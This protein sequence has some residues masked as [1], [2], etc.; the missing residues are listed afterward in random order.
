MTGGLVYGDDHPYIGLSGKIGSNFTW[1]FMYIIV[2]DDIDFGSAGGSIMDG[3][4]LDWRV[5]SIKGKYK[6]GNGFIISP[7]YAFSDNSETQSQDAKVHYFGAEAYGKLGLLTPRFEFAY[8]TGETNI[9]PAT[10]LEYD[11]D[12]FAWYGSVDVNI[13]PEFVPYFG[14]SW[15]SGDDND[16]DTDIDAFNGVTDIARYTPTFGIENAMVYRL[17]LAL[18]T[19]LYSGTFDLLAGGANTPGYGGI[20]NSGSGSAGGLIQ[21]GVGVKGAIGNFSYK[22]QWLYFELEEE[23][24]L[25]D[26][27]GKNIDT[28]I[29]TEWDLRIA[30][31]FSNHFTMANCFSAFDPGDAIQDIRGAAFDDTAILDTLEFIWSW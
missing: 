22:A 27:Y 12:A 20:S 5:Y 4:T 15:L 31:K 11:I 30:Y 3:D 1:D 17:N 25:E 8:A 21:Y 2:Q 26:I 29:G 16:N 19:H 6:M 14:I 24:A 7:F 23:G 28:E 9:N 10:G 18:G 13:M